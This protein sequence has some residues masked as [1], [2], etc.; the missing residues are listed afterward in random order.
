MPGFDGTGPRGEGPMTGGGF[1]YCS[2]GQ[3][4]RPRFGRGAFGGRGRG[5]RFR[6]LSVPGRVLYPQVPLDKNQ[7]IQQLKQDKENLEKTL[8]Q[9]NKRISE[10]EG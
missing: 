3:P 4:A 2:G 5:N 10:L 8:E 9:L 1:G 7:E 6:Y